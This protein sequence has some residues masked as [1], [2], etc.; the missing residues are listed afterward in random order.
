[1]EIMVVV[2]PR[3]TCKDTTVNVILGVSDLKS[4]VSP[5]VKSIPITPIVI[6]GMEVNEV[7]YTN[8]Y[9]ETAPVTGAGEP[10][11]ARPC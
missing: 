6:V 5:G 1:M 11:L 7:G 4:S 3:V 10:Q 8:A 2:A 9:V